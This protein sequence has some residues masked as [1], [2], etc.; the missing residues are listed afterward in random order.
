MTPGHKRIK[1]VSNHIMYALVLGL[2]IL[3]F[4]ACSDKKEPAKDQSAEGSSD[5]FTFFELGKS[6]RF[7]EGVRKNLSRQLG[8]DAIE[9]RG[10]FNLEINY[11]GFLQEHFPALH[12]LNAQFNPSSGERI[13]HNILKLMYRYARKKNLPFDFVELIFS[14]YSRL[15][16]VFKINFKK[17][18]AN[19]IQTL[20]SKYGE[21]RLIDW[22]NKNGQSMVWEK[23]GDILFVSLVPDQFGKPEY[24]IRIFF[25][26]NI[27]TLLEQ[28]KLDR[29]KQELRRAKSGQKAF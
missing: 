23:D 15:P 1:R 5:T 22:K 25:V 24:Q 2:I 16:L 28:E 26:D 4:S 20:K 7:S 18:E 21:P 13:E 8:N 10:L 27:Q 11:Y 17:D 19:V 9:K 12:A 6:S 14:N 3:M 29:E